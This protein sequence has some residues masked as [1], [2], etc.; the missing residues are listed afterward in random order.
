[1]AEE[2]KEKESV[3]EFAARLK[4]KFP[5]YIDKED[6]DLVTRWIKKYPEYTDRVDLEV[7]KKDDSEQ[8]FGQPSGESP[9]ILQEGIPFDPLQEV[10]V[11]QGVTG[12]YD[13]LDQDKDEKDGPPPI[14]VYGRDMG[15]DIKPDYATSILKAQ[16]QGL[17]RKEVTAAFQSGA[18]SAQ[19]AEKELGLLSSEEE[20]NG[21]KLREAINRRGTLP[22]LTVMDKLKDLKDNPAQILPFLSGAQE[23]EEMYQLIQA[24]DRLDA[25][26]A[27]DSDLLLLK[28]YQDEASRDKTFWHGVVD[29]LS[30]L[31]AFAGE[32]Y[33]TGGIYTVGKKA[34]IEAS[35]KVLKDL[36][37]KGGK[38]LLDQKLKSLT[39]KEVAKVI[40]TKSVGGI[41]G[42]S[43]QTIPAGATRITA[44]TLRHMLPEYQFSE[45][46]EGDLLAE[47]GKDV[48][49]NE[50]DGKTIFPAMTHALGDQWIETLSEKSGGLFTAMP[51][52]KRVKVL[53]TA[54]YRALRKANPGKTHSKVMEIAK[55]AG[56]DGVLQEMGEERLGEIGRFAIGLDEKY[57]PPTG[58]QLLQELIIF[59]IPGAGI[60]LVNNASQKLLDV[61][62][63][64]DAKPKA[65]LPTQEQLDEKPPSYKIGDEVYTKE[66]FEAVIQNP[67]AIADIKENE[68]PVEII[69]DSE[70]EALLKKAFPVESPLIEPEVKEEV[71]RE[72]KPVSEPKK[73]ESGTQETLRTTD[74]TQID[75]VVPMVDETSTIIDEKAP[76]GRVEASTDPK[77]NHSLKLK[78]TQSITTAWNRETSEFDYFNKKG[79]KVENKKTKVWAKKISESPTLMNAWWDMMASDKKKQQVRDLL[80]KYRLES[81]K[82]EEGDAVSSIETEILTWMRGTKFKMNKEISGNVTDVN[83]NKWSAKEG[84]DMAETLDEFV[85]NTLL[86]QLEA[87]GFNYTGDAKDMTDDILEVISQHPDGVTQAHI[88]EA[89]DR[90]DPNY[91]LLQLREEFVL[92]TGLD[93]DAITDHL[94]DKVYG[95]QEITT[96][97]TGEGQPE[98]QKDIGKPKEDVTQPI[99]KSETAAEKEITKEKALTPK[100]QAELDT[101]TKEEAVPLPGD[102][103]KA[104]LKEEDKGPTGAQPAKESKEL[105]KVEEADNQIAEGLS[106]LADAIGAK[107]AVVGGENKKVVAA[108][109]KIGNGIINKGVANFEDYVKKLWSAIKGHLSRDQFDSMTGELKKAW[110]KHEGSLSGIK[111]AKTSQ[112]SIEAAEEKIERKSFKEIYEDGKA[113]V[114][115]NKINPEELVQELLDNPRVISPEEVVWYKVPSDL[116]KI[117]Y[118]PVMSLLERYIHQILS[119]FVGPVD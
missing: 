108:V 47:I 112:E 35:K 37:T 111:K 49:G 11:L 77:V 83:L 119:D 7:K 33:L 61:A 9:S 113:L 90:I 46:E 115:S 118:R 31:P 110:E 78:V 21:K 6:L 64:R 42:A 51:T 43:L 66:E 106:D 27:S 96:D 14:D 68:T 58:E 59:S 94:T 98:V 109:L 5:E 48:E 34:T 102:Q 29:G 24:A 79:D 25:D 53:R 80:D 2:V 99:D 36:L 32:L 71:P 4:N 8:D 26:I 18:M 57:T 56:W 30:G 41:V 74:D 92:L 28:E 65:T 101:K 91:D 76:V 45:N 10:E 67:D 84:D 38:D 114:E 93:L 97:K 15:R 103:L 50:L 73:V 87:E 1:M 107:V 17:K 82:L 55:K 44:G 62:E 3:Q 117:A 52:P 86:P 63:K 16:E 54:I 40:A 116:Q 19:D 81:F 13:P 70:A 60:S 100:E 95:E 105:T 39:K 89:K 75:E 22:A 20:A 23:T 12:Y 69:N 104:D 88:Q 85:S 72:T